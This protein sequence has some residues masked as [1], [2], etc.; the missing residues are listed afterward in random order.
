MS[1]KS[2]IQRKHSHFAYLGRECQ[3]SLNPCH[4][5]RGL[6]YTYSG[7]TIGKSNALKLKS[8]DSLMAIVENPLVLFRACNGSYDSIY[9]PEAVVQWS[10][11][12]CYSVNIRLEVCRTEKIMI[13]I[14]YLVSVYIVNKVKHLVGDHRE[15]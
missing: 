7:K 10:T 13:P 6:V 2:I 12:S 5:Q 1:S 14:Q 15:H 4:L 3:V 9:E 11:L 8:M